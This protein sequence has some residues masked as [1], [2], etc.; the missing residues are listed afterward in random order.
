MNKSETVLDLL[1]APLPEGQAVL[2]LSLRQRIL[3][4][5]ALYNSER[6]L[7]HTFLVRAGDRIAKFEVAA[8]VTL[9][10]ARISMQEIRQFAT[11]SVHET[12]IEEAREVLR[13]QVAEVDSAMLKM[14][15]EKCL[16][17]GCFEERVGRIVQ[18]LVDTYTR[19]GV[20][21]EQ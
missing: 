11:E 13:K 6:Q 2:E 5:A 14:A 8:R 19:D 3:P 15:V 18:Q 21:I 1:C 9:A 20:V 16:A 4:E 17:D 12:I 7:Q 10:P